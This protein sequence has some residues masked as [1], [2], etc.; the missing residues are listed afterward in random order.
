MLYLLIFSLLAPD[1][2]Y[3]VGIRRVAETLAVKL[4]S[5]AANLR[6]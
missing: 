2:G 3:T 5:L 4:I 1:L 6:I